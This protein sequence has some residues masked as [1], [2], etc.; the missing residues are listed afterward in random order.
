MG[1]MSDRH[2]DG[3]EVCKTAKLKAAQHIH[4][5]VLALAKQAAAC[6]FKTLTYL[7]SM[8]AMDAAECIRKAGDD[9]PTRPP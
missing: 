7:L 1:R 3:S 8:A 9:Q 6:K 5:S 4:D 2:D